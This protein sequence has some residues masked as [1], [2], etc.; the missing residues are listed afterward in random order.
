MPRKGQFPLFFHWMPLASVS[1]FI[2][3]FDSNQANADLGK[4]PSSQLPW[5]L[6]PSLPLES[7]SVTQAALQLA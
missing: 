3:T 1:A 4:V 2:F 7:A 6:S 5:P